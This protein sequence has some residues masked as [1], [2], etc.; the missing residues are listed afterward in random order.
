MPSCTPRSNPPKLPP[1]TAVRTL[2]RVG[3]FLRPY[4][5]DASSLAALALVVAA[6]D[7]AIGQGL[8]GVIDRGF[9]AGDAAELDRTLG[10]MLGVV[11][12]DGRG[13]VHALLHRLVAGRAR[14][15]RPATR[16]VRAPA[17]AAAGVL[18]DHAHRRGDLAPDQRHDDAGDGDRQ[19]R[20]RWRRAT[21]CC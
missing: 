3:R 17:D 14:D 1:A 20:R 19:R 13:D 9:A 8:K 7:A 15:R 10:L 11:G 6:G 12:G 2:A 21:C 16:G 5:C 18:R 4:R